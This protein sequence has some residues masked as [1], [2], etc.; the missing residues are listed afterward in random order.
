M[1]KAGTKIADGLVLH[2]YCQGCGGV[3][4]RKAQLPLCGY[5]IIKY[6]AIRSKLTTDQLVAS[7]EQ[8]LKGSTN[9]QLQDH[10]GLS[11]KDCAV[12]RKI[13]SKRSGNHGNTSTRKS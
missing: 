13:F 7:A 10:T 12:V 6:A 11:G 4:Y 1:I 3:Q 5:C 8:I 9:R 2:G